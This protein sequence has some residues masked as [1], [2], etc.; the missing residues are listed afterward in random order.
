[1]N[2]ARR[3]AN[4]INPVGVGRAVLALGS[5]STLVLTRTDDLFISFAPHAADSRCVGI[6]RAGGF[7]LS[8]ALTGSRSV[9]VAA[10]IA[11]L[12]LVLTGFGARALAIPHFYVAWSI[13]QN[14]VV[15]E[16][17]DQVNAVIV[18]LLIP[19]I[20]TTPR[21]NAWARRTRFLETLRMNAFAYGAAE[22]IRVQLSVVYLVAAVAKF[23]VP[24]W[25]EGSALWYWLQV[26][27]FGIP[28]DVFTALA[29][30]LELPAILVTAT[31]AV[32]AF[33]LLLA[34]CI[35]M[36][37]KFARSVLYLGIAFHAGIA[38]VLGLWSFGLT[39]TGV[40]LL[41]L[42]LQTANVVFVE[43]QHATPPIPAKM[44][45]FTV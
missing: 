30:I 5:L 19:W 35:W 20:F 18:L 2:E 6:G 1:M 45:E 23:A 17:G 21:G 39:M 42:A 24:Q 7:C 36:R 4:S 3:L 25:S 26:P 38:L 37:S 33:E 13:S 10:S 44:E 34:V 28:E 14:I 43:F 9:G 11:I 31:Y 16:G 32:M 22:L 41:C 8:D 29:P 12:L 27:G 15:V 40:L